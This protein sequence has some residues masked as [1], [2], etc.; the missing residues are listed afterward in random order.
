MCSIVG[1]QFRK[2]AF[3]STLDGFLR[4][5]EL[6]RNLL[7]GIP[8]RDQSQY[9]DFCRRQSVVSSMLHDFVRDLWRQG[10][11]ADMD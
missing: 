2:D 11:L 5:R 1:A 10:L 6:S 7:V 9:K 3:D 4:D 8:G